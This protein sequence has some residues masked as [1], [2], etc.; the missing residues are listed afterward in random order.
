MPAGGLGLAVSGGQH[1]LLGD[2][3]LGV[4]AVGGAVAQRVLHGDQPVG[5]VPG[6]GAL[7]V[8]GVALQHQAAKVVAQVQA[9]H[10]RGVGVACNRLGQ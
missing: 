6:L 8:V 7:A 10:L 1:V 9:Q 4:V 2:A 3:A 5:F